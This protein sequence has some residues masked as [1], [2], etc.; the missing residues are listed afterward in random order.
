MAGKA[1]IAPA[2]PQPVEAEIERRQVVGARQGVVHE[3][4]RHHLARAGIVD[5]V[6]EQ[7]LADPLGHRAV[8]LAGGD[9]GID[10]DAVIVDRGVARQGDPAGLAVDLD[11]DDMG[12]V[13]EGQVLA[14][15]GMVG[16]ERLALFPPERRHLHQADGAVGA[17]DDEAAVG[18]ADVGLGRLER[19]GGERRALGDDLVRRAPHRRAAHVG[20]ARAAM[21]A[22]RHD[23]VGVALA[24]PDALVGHA[25]PMGEDLRE[26][27]LVT[28]ADMLRA[29]D[30][31][32]RAVGLEAHVDI[33][34]G[35]AAGAL[36]VV[37][38]AHPAQLAGALASAPSRGKTRQVGA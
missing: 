31:R 30:Q 18:E 2:S 34:V 28:L 15:P 13:G 35:R 1:A 9:H 12:A 26:G 8:R 17:G 29:G 20:G 10:Q 25:Q 3:R 6:L 38:E 33:L 36:D 11:L 32:D 5:G 37:G 24:Q 23:Q 27:R 14:G 16:V 21:T 19:I 7:R 4:S 22:A